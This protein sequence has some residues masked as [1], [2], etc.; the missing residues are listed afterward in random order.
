MARIFAGGLEDESGCDARPHQ[1]RVHGKEEPQGY[2]GVEP[3]RR[4][5]CGERRNEVTRPKL[6][7]SRCN[8]HRVIMQLTSG[9]SIAVEA[10]MLG[11]ALFVVRMKTMSLQTTCTLIYVFMRGL[12]LKTA[13]FERRVHQQTS[14]PCTPGVARFNCDKSCQI[15]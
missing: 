7:P 11:K 12:C 3:G 4:G 9:F 5:R 8:D 15:G 2:C 13:L 14:R 1:A 10:C 6:S